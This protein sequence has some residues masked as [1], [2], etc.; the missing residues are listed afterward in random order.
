MKN[1]LREI[2]EIGIDFLIDVLHTPRRIK[3]AKKAKKD[4]LVQAEIAEKLDNYIADFL[5]G[6]IEQFSGIPKKPELIDKKIIWQFWYQGIDENIPKVVKACFNSVKTHSNGYEIIML[7]KENMNDYIELPDFVWKRLNTGGYDITKLSNL[8]RLYLLSAYGGVWLDA[9][10]YLT[11]PIE[12]SLL[13]KDFFAFQRSKTLPLDANIYIKY[14]PLYFSWSP[15]IQ[16]RMLNSFMIAKP[17]NKI[18]SDLLSILL[19]Y[20]KKE[21]QT[22][23]YFFFQICFNR[24]IQQDEWKNLNCEIIGDTDCHRFLIAGFN[25]FNRTL[26]DKTTARMNIHKL[27]LY[28]ARKKIFDSSFAGF[29]INGK[30]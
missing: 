8:V 23:H 18:I 30:V 6:G 20:W 28:W 22:G 25:R 9:T 1:T 7:S 16:V 10:I 15:A 17:H 2:S 29:I 4:I 27:T 3:S 14:D 21:E 26:Y 11:K 24:M 5:S 19:E 13:Q 12:E